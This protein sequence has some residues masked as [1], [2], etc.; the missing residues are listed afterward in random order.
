MLRPLFY[1]IL[2]L[3]CLTSCKQWSTKPEDLKQVVDHQVDELK[4]ESYPEIEPCEKNT[5]NCFEEQL[6]N[7]LKLSL[8]TTITTKETL[9]KDTLWVFIKVNNKGVI[10]ANFQENSLIVEKIKPSIDSSLTFIN[11]IKPGYIQGIPVTCN[12]KLPLIINKQK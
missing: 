1:G 6:S 10:D 4:L 2:L 5:R 8:D 7:L 3:A 12:F 11:P 9:V